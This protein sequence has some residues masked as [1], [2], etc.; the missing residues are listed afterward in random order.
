MSEARLGCYVY[1][2]I[3]ADERP[4]L[5]ALRGVDPAFGV[6]LVTRGRLSAVVSSV[7]LDEFGSE[8]LKRNLED[9][10]WLERTARAHQAVLERALSSSAVVPMRLCTIFSDEAHV[11][12][13][14]DREEEVLLSALERLQNHSEWSVKVLADPAQVEAAARARR[15]GSAA[16]DAG[17]EGAGRAYLA[18]K[19]AERGLREEA[20]AMLEGA[21]EEIHARLS[22]E[23]AAATVLAPQNPKLSGR[24]GEMVLNGA[25][26]VH[27]S[28][29][30]DFA[31]AV[32]DLR[33][34]HRNLSLQLELGGPWAPYNFVAEAQPA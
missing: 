13:M 22:E 7:S 6:K 28:G 5:D 8:T 3:G 31:E 23:A 1:C 29:V 19:K 25:Y 9:L 2:V 24:T 34:R 15:Q 18:R 26:L 32:Q 14:L 12:E 16:A 21:A 17:A 11:R 33:Q 30:T 10:E 20:R 4:P 27:R